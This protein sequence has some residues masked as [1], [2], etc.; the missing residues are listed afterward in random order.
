MREFMPGIP[1]V[2]DG[3]CQAI[4]VQQALDKDGPNW[5][6]KLGYWPGI[7]QVVAFGR[8]LYGVAELVMSV[9]KTS[10]KADGLYHI[11]R[12]RMEA[13]GSKLPY[14]YDQQRIQIITREAASHPYD[15]LETTLT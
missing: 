12:A 15:S 4:A 6:D 8:V 13:E 3:L 9:V 2:E 7:G 11:A 1:L 5:V 14:L 10:L